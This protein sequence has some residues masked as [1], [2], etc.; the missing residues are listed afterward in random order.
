MS[1]RSARSTCTLVSHAYCVAKS[2]STAVMLCRG[3]ANPGGTFARLVGNG[4]APAD[5]P[6]T[7][8]VYARGSPLLRMALS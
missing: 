4:G 6:E 8:T 7:V 5:V 2:G 3:S 1:L